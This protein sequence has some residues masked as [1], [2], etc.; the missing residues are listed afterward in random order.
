MRKMG[1]MKLM[2][3]SRKNA[4]VTGGTD[5]VG[6]EVAR[7]L[8]RAGHRVILVGRDAEKGARVEQEMRETT[9][10]ADVQ[11]LQVDLSLVREANRLADDIAGRWPALHYLIHS[12]GVV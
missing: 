7:G 12:A 3:G 11:F 9:G 1:R 2:T 10:N 6:K 4:L 5:G 8:A